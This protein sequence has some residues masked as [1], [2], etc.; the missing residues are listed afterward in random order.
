MEFVEKCQ[1]KPGML[2]QACH[3]STWEAETEGSLK[4][5]ASPGYVARPCLTH[6]HTHTNNKYTV[7]NKALTFF[8]YFLWYWGL[9]PGLSRQAFYHLSYIPP[10]L[11]ICLNFEFPGS[12][13]KK[14]GKSY[15]SLNELYM[16]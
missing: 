8:F 6:T 4:F 9:N 15:S 10:V 2:V 12:Q 1:D 13:S 11:F 7:N 16:L 3:P 5:E 14:K